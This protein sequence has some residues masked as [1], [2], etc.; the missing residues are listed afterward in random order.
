MT[1]SPHGASVEILRPEHAKPMVAFL[2]VAVVCGFV[3]ANGLR[4]PDAVVSILRGGAANI[5]AGTTLLHEPILGSRLEERVHPT[6]SSPGSAPSEGGAVVVVPAVA[7]HDVA[8]GPVGEPVPAQGPWP[9]HDQAAAG[10]NGGS[11]HAGGGQAGGAAPANTNRDNGSAAGHAP[12]TSPGKSHAKGHAKAKHQAQR[13]TSVQ[14]AE[15]AW[16]S[17]VDQN[18][19]PS[20]Q[21]RVRGHGK[22]WGKSKDHHGRTHGKKKGHDKSGPARNRGK[23]RR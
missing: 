7:G 23:G 3:F 14:T 6:V 9:G 2:A 12:A 4:T 22:A 17:L 10:G 1:H 19:R 20:G 18:A 8:S 5:V 15:T 16:A 21:D 11:Q 13:S